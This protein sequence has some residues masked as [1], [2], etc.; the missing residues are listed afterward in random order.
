M[1]FIKRLLGFDSRYS[2]TKW[3]RTSLAIVA[4]YITWAFLSNFLI[5][6]TSILGIFGMII[7][8]VIFMALF[9]PLLL[10][11]VGASVLVGAVIGGTVSGVK[12]RKSFKETV[13]TGSAE[14]LKLERLRMKSLGLDILMMVLFALLVAGFFVLAV[15]LIETFGEIGLYGYVI[16]SVIVLLVFSIAKAPVKAAYKRAF[17]EQVVIKGLEEVLPDMDFRPQEKLDETLVRAANL[18]PNYNDYSGN[19][20]LAADY[21]GHHFVQ[22]DV[23][24]QEARDETYPD[25]DGNLCVRTVYT[26]LFRGR[27]MILDYDAI[28]D[29]PVAV[30]DRKGGTPKI[31]EMIQTELDV[32]NQKFY[33]RSSNPTDALRILTP[34]VLEGIVLARG[35]V[36]CP[37]NLSFKDDRLY[38]AMENGDSFEAAEGDATLSE[39]RRRVTS[40]IQAMLDLFDTLYLKKSITKD[41]L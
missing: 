15:P 6:L 13:S 33:I 30:L 7:A 10:L 27:L 2:W 34:P 36:G 24:L 31:N 5:P 3:V 28:S 26:T 22:S 29:E 9:L 38:V 32:F 17:K 41:N 37:L 23:H 19:D 8:A 16:V 18:F 14:L 12:Q 11:M 1:K 39:Q 21:H 4:L 35:K 40:D 20:Y 25:E